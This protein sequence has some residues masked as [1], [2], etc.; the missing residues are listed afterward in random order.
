M[1]GVVSVHLL[2]L[3]TFVSVCKYVMFQVI[4]FDTASNFLHKRTDLLDAS[5]SDAELFYGDSDAALPCNMYVLISLFLSVC[6]SICSAQFSPETVNLPSHTHP[7][8]SRS[9]DFP[10]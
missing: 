1:F 4:A 5:V 10:C 2:F 9:R 3:I 6:G 8:T 7:P